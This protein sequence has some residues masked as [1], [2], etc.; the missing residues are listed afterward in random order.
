MS[1]PLIFGWGK[2]SK[3]VGYIGLQKCPVC[4]HFA[5][6]TINEVANNIKVYFIPIAKYNKKR[7]VVCGRCQNG[8]E[9]DE[10]KYNILMLESMKAFTPER[11]LELWKD[12]SKAITDFTND[13]AENDFAGYIIPII[14]KY[15]DSE[16]VYEHIDRLM[17]HIREGIEPKED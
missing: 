2:N 8:W 12:I 9:L 5:N 16:Y 1:I 17:N 15:G 10:D 11:T 3:E 7:Y 4:N 14:N 13:G 6:F